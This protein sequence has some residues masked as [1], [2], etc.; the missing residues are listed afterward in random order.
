MKYF[1]KRSGH[2]IVLLAATD[3]TFIFLT[4]LL[5]PNAL[6]GVGMF[7]L[8]FTAII[9]CTGCF[10]EHR[11]QLQYLKT[12]EAFCDHPDEPAMRQLSSVLGTFWQPSVHSLYRQ[13]REQSGLLE[14]AREQL[15]SYQEYIESWVHEI[16]TPLSLATL[17]LDNYRDEMSPHVYSRMTYVRHLISGH[18]DHILYYARLQ[19]SHADYKFERVLLDSCVRDTAS[20]FLSCAEER[21]V[22]L[23]Q[24]LEP[25]TAVTDQKI[26]VFILSQLLSNGI[27]YAAPENGRVAVRLWKESSPGLRVHLAVR[28]NGPGVPPEDAPFLFDKGFTGSHPERQKATGMGLYFVKKYAEALSIETGLETDLP[29]GY[30]F[31][32]ELIFPDVQEP[33][34]PVFL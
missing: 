31:A 1:L 30:G 24:E 21:H 33:P 5:R 6:R 3:L 27:K 13:L 19:D 15:K 2:W 28:D 16:K 29:P 9:V 11:R 25:L 12:L 10:L 22:T 17:V 26:L 8:L 4:W 32:I 20:D 14:E 23:L 34:A 18:V 7:I